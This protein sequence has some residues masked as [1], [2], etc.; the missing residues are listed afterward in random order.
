VVKYNTKVIMLIMSGMC[1]F[2]QRTK[3]ALV[4]EDVLVAPARG[5]N[6]AQGVAVE[7]NR[8]PVQGTGDV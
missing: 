8:Q 2:L 1:V 6:R 7:G 3:P 4:L 5:L